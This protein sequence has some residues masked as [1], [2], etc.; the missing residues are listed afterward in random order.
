MKNLEDLKL[1]IEKLNKHHQIE[2]LKIF[3][4]NLCKLNENKSGVYINLSFVDSSVI[5]E[6]EKYLQYTKEQ[7]ETLNTREYQKEDFKSQYFIDKED[8]EYSSKIYSNN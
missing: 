1:R 3:S 2:I 6:L 7:E 8:K 5:D 4:K